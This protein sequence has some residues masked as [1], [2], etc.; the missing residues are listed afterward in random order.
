MSAPPDGPAY[1]RLEVGDPGPWFTQRTAHNP[2]FVLDVTA[3]R[4][5]VLGFYGSAGDAAGRA[6]LDQILANRHL[7][8]DTRAA[9]FGVAIDPER[10]ERGPG[11]R[12]DP[13]HPLFLR[14]RLHRLA[15]LRRRAAR[16]RPRRRRDPVPALLG[17]ARPDAARP[18]HRPLRR[19]PAELFALLAALPPPDRFAGIALQAP[20]PLP[21]RRLRAGVL[22]APDR[23]LRAPRRRGIRLHARDRRQDRRRAGPQP[24]AAAR[25]PHRGRG[26]SSPPPAAASAA[27]SCRRSRRSTSS[28]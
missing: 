4:Y 20:D 12:R 14:F 9:F 25:L 16:R 19:G 6:A 27:A 17:G 2:R 8:D 13:R 21:A 5:I 11:R 15:P 22:P 24:Q 1:R 10:R 26:R 7:F 23:A 28:R 3:G 18:R